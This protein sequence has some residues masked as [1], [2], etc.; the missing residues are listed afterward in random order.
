MITPARL[1]QDYADGFLYLGTDVF[2]LL[3]E[4][5]NGPHIYLFLAAA[6]HFWNMLDSSHAE[7]RIAY[8]HIAC[9]LLV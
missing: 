5:P 8:E 9:V 2:I 1:Q 7:Q 3:W 6:A 4:R